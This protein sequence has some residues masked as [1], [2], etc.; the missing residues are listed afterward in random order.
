MFVRRG[1]LV[2]VQV[3][4]LMGGVGGGGVVVLVWLWPGWWWR[5]RSGAG[6][7]AT[8]GAGAGVGVA[9]GVVAVACVFAGWGRRVV[10]CHWGVEFGEALVSGAMERSRSFQKVKFFCGCL[11]VQMLDG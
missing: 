10:R 4:M 1:A 3:W 2:L 9:V 11:I 5:R 7:V 8:V 6:L